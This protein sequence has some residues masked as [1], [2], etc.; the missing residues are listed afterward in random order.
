[1]ALKIEFALRYLSKDY[2]VS[3]F[4]FVPIQKVKHFL[5][6][7]NINIRDLTALKKLLLHL[8]KCFN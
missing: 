4:P 7:G 1:M 5:E 8:T 6:V 3:S 2:S